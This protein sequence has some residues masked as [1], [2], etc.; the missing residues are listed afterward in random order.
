LETATPKSENSAY[1]SQ[2]KLVDRR[3]ALVTGIRGQD[4]FYL[5]Q[6]LLRSGLRV[7]GLSRGFNGH[8]RVDSKNIPV[9]SIDYGNQAETKKLLC[10]LKPDFIFHLAAIASSGQK[11]SERD[12][13]MK[14]NV[15][16]TRTVLNEIGEVGNGS[17]V[18]IQSLSS[19]IFSA[20]EAGIFDENSESNPDNY[21][22]ESKAIARDL[23]RD[24]RRNGLNAVAAI[25]FSHESPRRSRLFFSRK[26]SMGVAEIARNPK[27]KLELKNLSGSRDWG[28]AR[29][30]TDALIR[31]ALSSA[32]EYIVA[33]GK[34]RSVR[35][36]CEIAFKRVGL[37][38]REF[39]VEFDGEPT[40][41]QKRAL[42]GNAFRLKHELKWKQETSFEDLIQEMV[43]YD[44]QLLG[45]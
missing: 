14:I 8:I 35:E 41:N 32:S 42:V 20:H 25:L 2:A 36:F 26:V 44:V 11:F 43:D 31:M 23:L 17:Q 3:T 28:H 27:L 10:A 45:D 7:V 9:S 16:W 34:L 19:E 12:S 38:Y 39:V 24:A 37:D 18:F 1:P 21:Y 6:K 15:E 22:G 33:S 13:H 30:Y 40:K 29:D 4:G 5:A